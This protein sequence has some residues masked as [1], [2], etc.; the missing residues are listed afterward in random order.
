[1]TISGADYSHYQIAL[2]PGEI[3]PLSHGLEMMWDD[4]KKMDKKHSCRMPFIVITLL[5]IL[6]LGKA[7]ARGIIKVADNFIISEEEQKVMDMMQYIEQD[8]QEES[9]ITVLGNCAYIYLGSERNSA[10][11]FVYTYPVCIDSDELGNEFVNQLKVEKPQVIV[12]DKY[13]FEGT[14]KY[15]NETREILDLNYRLV[16]EEE[17]FKVYKRKN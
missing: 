7:G 4:L 2:L 8:T 12:E 16:L 17:R 1:M 15:E 13:T 9:E 14:S 5:G 3:L 6:F 10:T 11:D